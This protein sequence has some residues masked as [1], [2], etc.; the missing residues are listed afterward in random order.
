MSG[1]T[2]NLFDRPARDPHPLVHQISP[3]GWPRGGDESRAEVLWVRAA[4]QNF[5][6]GVG[7]QGLVERKQRSTGD[8]VTSP[9]VG[10]GWENR[11]TIER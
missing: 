4:W 8:A 1:G 10:R 7:G 3:V 11:Y 9:G 6:I 2:Q 5:S